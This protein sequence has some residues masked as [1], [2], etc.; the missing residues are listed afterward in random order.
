MT[1]WQTC[2]SDV[3]D[4]TFNIQKETQNILNN[5]LVGIYLHGSLAMGGFNP[6]KSDIDLLVVTKYPVN[7]EAKKELTQLFLN[8][9]SQPYPVEISVLN[10]SQLQTWQHP[11]PFD[12]HYGED[13]R[14]KYK[15]DF[16]S[17][18]NEVPLTDP[19]LAAHITIMNHYGISLTGPPIDEIFPKIPQSDYKSSI[20]EDYNDCLEN[21][22]D[23]PVYCVLNLLR[24]YWYLKEE[25][26]SSKK[27]AGEWGLVALPEKFH[28]TIRKTVN[29]YKGVKEAHFNREEL[30][31]VRNYISDR[32]SR[33][34]D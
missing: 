27:E 16:E 14:E 7:V 13:W 34:N 19:D 6:N 2:S 28:P 3:K 4:F 8:H 22:E 26:I 5:N 20:V 9:S 30:L 24:V 10:E 12:F 18:I 29:E 17:F 31:A 32:V 23:N 11:S 33:L 15:N 1:N 25:V 21:I